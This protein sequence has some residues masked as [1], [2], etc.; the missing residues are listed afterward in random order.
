M[1]TIET[2]ICETIE[3]IA[4]NLIKKAEFDK[5]IQATIVACVDEATGKYK[6]KY[7]DNTFYAF[8]GDIS[9]KYSKSTRVYVLVPGNDMTRDK[10]ILGIVGQAVPYSSTEKGASYEITS[11]NLIKRQSIVGY[12][13]YSGTAYN[14]NIYNNSDTSQD[15]LERYGKNIYES[16]EYSASTIELED[17]NVINSYMKNSNSILFGA[18]FKTNLSNDIVEGEYGLKLIMVCGEDG[19]ELHTETL[20]LDF[21]HGINGTYYKFFEDTE[22]NYVFPKPDGFIGIAKIEF[23]AKNFE[24]QEQGGIPESLITNGN[25]FVKNL[26]IQT[27]NLIDE[28]NGNGIRLVFPNSTVLRSATDTLRVEAKVQEQNVVMN[29]D[30]NKFFWFK[31]DLSVVGTSNKGYHE[32]GGQGWYC[33]NDKDENKQ[34]EPASNIFKFGIDNYL[35]TYENVFKVVSYREAGNSVITY[36]KEFKLTNQL[37]QDF[38]IKINHNKDKNVLLRTA[39]DLE[40]SCFITQMMEG[41][42]YKYYWAV[43]TSQ[44]TIFDNRNVQLFLNC[45][46]N[47]REKISNIWHYNKSISN[48]HLGK[49]TNST[50][51]TFYCTVKEKTG[52]KEVAL[53]T[54]SVSFSLT[55]ASLED[56]TLEF[57]NNGGSQMF[58][59]DEYGNPPTQNG[60]LDLT[61]LT[62]RII[63]NKT[64]FDVDINH[65]IASKNLT[66]QWEAPLDESSLLVTSVDPNDGYLTDGI[67]TDEGTFYK[68]LTYNLK[69]PYTNKN[70]SNNNITVNVVFNNLLYT[71]TT[72]FSFNAQGDSGTNGTIYTARIV[73]KGTENIPNWV[74]FSTTGLAN[75][76][77][78]FNSYY[79]D[80][81]Y[82]RQNIDGTPEFPFNV[83]LFANG[84][85]IFE[86]D[87]DGVD[88]TSS[89]SMIN[90]NESI[91][92]LIKVKWSMA[93]LTY[94]G[95]IKDRSNFTI[96]EKYKISGDDSGT[97]Y[98]TMKYN[99]LL[100]TTSSDRSRYTNTDKELNP[101]N[102]L[103]CEVTYT[104]IINID[105]DTNNEDDYNGDDENE[106][107]K[108]HSPDSSNSENIE[109]EKFIIYASL[110]IVTIVNRQP[111]KYTLELD[112]NSGY[113]EVTYDRDSS[114]PRYA[115]G[116]NT[117][118]IKSNRSIA[119]GNWYLKG[120]DGFTKDKNNKIKFTMASNLFKLGG[121]RFNYVTFTNSQVVNPVYRSNGLSV[122]NAIL[123]KYQTSYVHIPIDI[124]LNRYGLAMFN[125]WD[126]NSVEI[127]NEGGYIIAPQLAA[128]KKDENNTFTGIAMGEAKEESQRDL[129][130]GLYAY[131]KG[132][133]TFGLIADTGVV[134]IGPRSKGQIVLNPATNSGFIYSGN[135]FRENPVYKANGKLDSTKPVAIDEKTGLVDPKILNNLWKSNYDINTMYK[136]YIEKTKEGMLI[137][138]SGHIYFANEKF[139]LKPNGH[140]TCKSGT[141]A[142]FQIDEK[143]MTSGSSPTRTTTTDGK[144]NVTLYTEP[145]TRYGMTIT[146]PYGKNVH[147]ETKNLL[148]YEWGNNTSVGTGEERIHGSFD[149]ESI[150]TGTLALENV[151][152]AI[153]D[154]FAVRKD[155]IV[156]ARKACISHGIFDELVCTDLVINRDLTVKGNAI[157]KGNLYVTGNIYYQYGHLIE[158]DMVDVLA[159]DILVEDVVEPVD[160]VEPDP[161]L[162]DDY[163]SSDLITE[164]GDVL[165][166]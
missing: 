37:Y 98:L 6:V 70:L 49:L 144:E 35:T 29:D 110:P 111:N 119:A 36:T 67:E 159:D 24:E 76:N 4:G 102:I 107:N 43:E 72:N 39:E 94:E 128:G 53:G 75:G 83:Q 30:A 116:S 141:I 126:G 109:K 51:I 90:E 137:D 46:F 91:S 157:V 32:L 132:Q 140:L 131:N 10:T 60:L 155:G 165:I 52:S 59:Y 19:G 134:T 93:T 163:G 63:D 164:G 26:N 153:G 129:Q 120:Y 150:R 148:Y 79:M 40:L 152:F 117:F 136:R 56:Y 45:T 124:H 95:N 81:N 162:V 25:I 73:P 23:F 115:S 125:E 88:N 156:C 89:Y 9:K 44:T 8:T 68:T 54:A 108:F 149:V 104:P 47:K 146:S 2:T 11:N 82:C 105:M 77:F 121:K 147:G 71:K 62:I 80:Q 16:D 154:D 7:Q 58:L 14:L 130:T 84:K 1:A 86:G 100:Y 133:R 42:S 18:S 66:I 69:G 48:I 78:N 41:K 97:T 50:Y 92:S 127:N 103:K 143:G 135:F 21:D 96:D 61:P 114:I 112:D 158:R 38:E 87:S 5:T 34:W 106:L 57:E 85:M 22:C 31:R 74:T 151:L 139:H 3:A 28:V 166:G 101:A 20:S 64:G 161:V 142:N 145:F 113:S 27:C 160:L 138:F 118:T 17:V 12:E 99:R 122:T 15:E 13:I 33:L 55:D 123:F 65:E